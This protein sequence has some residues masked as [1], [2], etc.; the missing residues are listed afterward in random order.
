MQIS[1]TTPSAD[2]ALARV[3]SAASDAAAAMLGDYPRLDRDAL[4][5]GD[6]DRRPAD[7]GMLAILGC[8]AYD[9]VV[10]AASCQCGFSW[11]SFQGFWLVARRVRAARGDG[12]C[13]A[14]YPRLIHLS[15]G[16][17]SETFTSCLLRAQPPVFVPWQDRKGRR[18][19]WQ[20]TAVEECV[21]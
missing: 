5:D 12:L 18:C 19:A 7:A 4:L 3:L 10:E 15:I 14:G 8:A 17:C 16:N 20:V 9:V 1:N 13:S 2:A 11:C 6:P 21:L